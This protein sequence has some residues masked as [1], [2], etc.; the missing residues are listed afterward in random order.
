M[1]LIISVVVV[2][3]LMEGAFAY[4]ISDNSQTECVKPTAM[5]ATWY[6]HCKAS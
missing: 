6:G 3:L 2:I 5:P 1:K 4:A